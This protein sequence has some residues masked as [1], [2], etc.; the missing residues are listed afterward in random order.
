MC[1][2]AE[3]F[4]AIGAAASAVSAVGSLIGKPKAAPVVQQPQVDA[5]RAADEA[6]QE[7]QRK[8]LAQRR[9]ARANSLLAQA[10]GAGDLTDQVTQTMGAAGK[11][12]L[13]S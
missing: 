2:G 1:T 10:G 4:G 5:A 9:A 8:L 7:A 13:G 11:V 12:S 6:G 3:I